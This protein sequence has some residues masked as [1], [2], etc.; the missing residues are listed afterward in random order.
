MLATET[1]ILWVLLPVLQYFWWGMCNSC[2]TLF[3]SNFVD[4][5]PY[6]AEA[7]D[8]DAI[9]SD[10]DLNGGGREAWSWG[11]AYLRTDLSKTGFLLVF[12]SLLF[13]SALIV[14]DLDFFYLCWKH[15]LPCLRK[16][17]GFGQ[18]KLLKNEF[19][20][21]IHRALELLNLWRESPMNKFRLL[22]RKWGCRCVV[23]RECL[24]MSCIRT[25]L[26]NKKR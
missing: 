19:P 11:I 4:L 18:H 26:S 22:C 25:G 5:G 12:L 17:D 9:V 24:Q 3:A 13:W 8:I 6:E 7:L 20:H 15:L 2:N 23:S 21:L 16:S 1:L 14:T 10:L